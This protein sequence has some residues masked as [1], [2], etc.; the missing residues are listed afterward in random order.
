MKI[1]FEVLLLLQ[2]FANIQTKIEQ[3]KI[4]DKLLSH[5]L[6]F[7]FSDEQKVKNKYFVHEVL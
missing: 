5:H 7:Y 4:F 3:A 1:L 2:R 6:I